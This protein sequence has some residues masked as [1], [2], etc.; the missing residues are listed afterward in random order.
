[1]VADGDRGAVLWRATGTFAGEPR[2]PGHRG[3]PAGA[4]SSRLRPVHRPRRADR[5][6]R[7]VH[8]RDRVRAPDRDAPRPGTGAET[9]VLRAFNASTRAARR[10]AGTRR[11]AGRRRRVDRARRLAAGMNVYFVR[12][13]DGVPCSTPASGHG[14]GARRRGERSSAGSPA[15]CSATATSTTAAPRPGCGAPG[16]LP[17]RRGAQTPRATAASTTST[18]TSCGRYARPL[19]RRLLKSWDGGPVTIAG[20]LGEGDEVERLPRRPPARPRARG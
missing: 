10:L 8:R 14:P 7:R 13:G 9:A 5:R 18:S 2:L 12:D 15:S 1:M 16:L 17:P 6:Q 11:R 19:Y 3:R 20:T 4:W